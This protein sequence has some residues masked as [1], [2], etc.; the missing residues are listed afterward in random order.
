MNSHLDKIYSKIIE[1]YNFEKENII[2]KGGFGIVYKIKRGNNYYAMKFI[3]LN[4]NKD[5]EALNKT[6]KL[7]EDELIR[8]KY[9]NSVYFIK[10]KN[11]FKDETE[12]LLIYSSVMDISRFSDLKY[13]LFSF[14]QNNIFKLNHIECIKKSMNLL[15]I[16]YFTIQIL[17]ALL[18]LKE[19]YLVHC[20]IKPENFL[21][22]SNFSLKLSDF[23]LLKVLKI[24]QDLELTS[25]TWIIKAKEYFENHKKVN[26]KNAYKVDIYTAGLVIYNLRYN[27]NI[28][29]K[30]YEVFFHTKDIDEQKKDL[31]VQKDKEAQEKINNDNLN[32]TNFKQLLISM[33]EPEI[34][35]R[36]NIEEL[37]TNK[38]VNK[39]LDIMNKIKNINE[40]EE[41]K[42]LFEFQKFNEKKYKKR[43]RN[44][45]IFRKP[46]KKK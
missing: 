43:K 21:F 6:K 28:I 16:K 45:F 46:Q 3:S 18:V 13:L 2:G 9:L 1:K 30:S 39:D 17:Y 38:W 34:S 36:P 35:D 41:I 4:K 25:T 19:H 37:L 44:K 8:S 5:K 42:L 10:T 40:S 11:I 15:L 29:D 22:G 24:N 33:I 27:Q 26:Y 20:D 7:V 32:D 14:Y 23:S 12:N 31:I